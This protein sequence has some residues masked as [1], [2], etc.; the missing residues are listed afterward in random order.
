MTYY[1]QTDD[2]TFTRE[3]STELENAGLQKTSTF[4]ASIVFLSGKHAYN[5][6]H[7]DLKRSALSNII[8]PISIT[9]KGSLHE[10]FEDYDFIMPTNERSKSSVRILK[11]TDSYAGK[12]IRIVTTSEEIETHMRDHPHPQWVLQDYI[13]T[14]ALKDNHKFHIRVAILV[15]SDKV[16]VC[17]KSPYYIAKKEYIQDRWDDA[18]IHDTHFSERKYFF[19]DDLPDGWKRASNKP[20]FDIVHQVFKNVALK[21]DWNSKKSY[22]LFGADIMFNKR[23]AILLEVNY[24]IGLKQMDF[25]VPGLVS[26]LMGHNHSDFTQVL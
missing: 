19:P 23:K 16:Y 10:E 2:P 17:N 7:K 20:I 12:D 3:L 4:P 9:D 14:P 6:N 13:R 22:Y 1:V 24:R 15:I 8:H 11:P 26:I 21:P 5:R 25:V 18:D